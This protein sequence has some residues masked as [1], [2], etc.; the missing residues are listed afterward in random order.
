MASH[1][2]LESSPVAV[3]VAGAGGRMGRMLIEAILHDQN[4]RLSAA[5]EQPDSMLIGQNAHDLA[6]TTPNDLPPLP[7]DS[8]LAGGLTVCDCLIDF[9]R[10][11]GT[12]THLRH[13]LDAGVSMVIGT[14]G[15]SQAE[16]EIIE[17]A[18][19]HIAIVFAPN[20]AVGVNVMFNLLNFAA[21]KLAGYDVEIVEAHH[22]LK[23]DAPSGTALK[24]GEVIAAAQQRQ[25]EDSAI[26]CRHG[27]TGERGSDTI[28]FATVRGGDIVGDHSAL[29]CGIGERIEITHKASNR[30]PY[31]QGAL[32]AACF[33]QGKTTG[34][35]DM[36][37]VLGLQ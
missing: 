7:L 16:K 25:L 33:L 35:Y 1:S 20:M 3:G 2:N 32:R 26:Y 15:F 14:T 6:A 10:P 29:F 12:L 4:A 34:L 5:F 27:H 18:S 9:T 17:N 24:M 11:A 21:Q 36:Q 8:D 23:V 22:R 30:M 28:G 19:R 31:A 37:D 13:C